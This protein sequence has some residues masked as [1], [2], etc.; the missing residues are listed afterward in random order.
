MPKDDGDVSAALPGLFRIYALVARRPARDVLRRRRCARQQARSAHVIGAIKRQAGR[1]RG[2][3]AAAVPRARPAAAGRRNRPGEARRAR[4]ATMLATIS[5]M[6][7][8]EPMLNE[9]LDVNAPQ[10]ARPADPRHHRDD[11]RSDRGSG[12]RRSSAASSAGSRSSRRRRSIAQWRTGSTRRRR[13]RRVAYATYIRSK[14]SGVVDSFARTICRLG[15]FP[16]E[17]NQAAFV[18]AVVHAWA[19]HAP[20]PRREG[21]AGAGRR[22]GRVPAHVRPA[23]QRAPAA[24][25]DRRPELV[26]RRGRQSPATRRAQRARRGQGAR[27]GRRGRCSSTRWTAASC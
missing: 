1:V 20:L 18:R 13:R 21:Q 6:P 10:R 4:A 22:P 3:P 26:V 17:S 2:R 15:D 11:V 14:V 19:E 23:V 25:R 5:G 27:C 12:W 16:A 8:K 9:I 24:L 7:R